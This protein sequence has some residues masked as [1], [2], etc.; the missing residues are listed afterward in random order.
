M[1]LRSFQ[2]IRFNCDEGEWLKFK[3]VEK[4]F[5]LEITMRSIALE[6]KMLC[7]ISIFS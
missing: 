5:Y 3:N 2:Q 1:N 6:R 7:L 4:L